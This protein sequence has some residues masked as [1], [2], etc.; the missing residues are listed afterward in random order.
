MSV[1][2]LRNFSLGRPNLNSSPQ[3]EVAR[4][5]TRI[6][7]EIPITLTSLDPRDQF[8]QPCVII[9]ANLRGCAVRSPRPV[10][11]GTTVRLEDLPA[12]KPVQ[13]RVVSCTSLG[14]FEKLWLLAL[15]LNEAGN[16]WGIN[17][18]PYD[19]KMP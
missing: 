3:K 14:E 6:P 10:P 12:K 18:M 2:I 15:A 11:A 5:G 9:L 8:S 13:A 16:V 17:P 4:G 19:W 7:C 1:E